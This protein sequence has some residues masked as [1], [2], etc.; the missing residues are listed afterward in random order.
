MTATPTSIHDVRIADRLIR[1][2]LARNVPATDATGQPVSLALAYVE[3]ENGREQ[4]IP[5]NEDYIR[6]MGESCIEQEIAR[7]IRV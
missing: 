3:H 7:A 6:F 1:Y 4:I 2:G 5:I